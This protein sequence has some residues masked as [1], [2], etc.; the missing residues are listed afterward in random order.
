M[1]ML[2]SYF[3][4]VLIPLA[5]VGGVSS[6]SFRSNGKAAMAMREV[7][8]SI[9]EGGGVS[10]REKT[11]V[12]TPDGRVMV[13]DHTGAVP[14]QAGSIPARKA[15]SLCKLADSR[16]QGVVSLTP[17]GNTYRFIAFSDGQRESRLTWS[18]EL[19]TMDPSL[20]RIVRDLEK[21]RF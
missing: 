15:A 10:G 11:W 20:M 8:L 14:R 12:L 2:Q 1:R 4:L 3:S 17:V 13:S 6:C 16:M 21:I 7:Q 9:G 19:P 5:V 18:G